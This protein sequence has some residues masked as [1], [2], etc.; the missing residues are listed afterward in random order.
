MYV[1]SV[2]SGPA[3]A[4][5]PSRRARRPAPPQ[6]F[7]RSGFRRQH[8]SQQRTAAAQPQP[9]LPLRAPRGGGRGGLSPAARAGRGPGGAAAGEPDQPCVLLRAGLADSPRHHAAVAMCM[10][11]AALPLAC[12]STLRRRVRPGA[13]LRRP[14]R[15][16]LLAAR[17]PPRA[18][19]PAG[20]ARQGAG[21]GQVVSG[22]TQAQAPQGMS[23]APARAHSP[24][25]AAPPA[26]G[27]SQAAP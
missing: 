5:W 21:Q 1:L 13:G 12:L 7:T 4:R 23:P 19:G 8:S 15:G 10:A 22:R 16:C 27:A 2:R 24:H 26:P 25:R 11:S 14:V 18:A 17:R 9:G 20:A 6:P 3:C